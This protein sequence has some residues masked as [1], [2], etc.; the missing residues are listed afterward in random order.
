MIAGLVVLAAL[1][2]GGAAPLADASRA[3]SP[4]AG[5]APARETRAALG[6]Y[7]ADPGEPGEPPER[8]LNPPAQRPDA[9]AGEPDGD[10]CG[11]VSPILEPSCGAWFG[12]WPRTRADGTS[13][14]DLYGNVV[15]LEQRLGRR[16]D[17]VT[18]YYGWTQLPFDQADRALRDGGR[19]LL[20]DV[21]ARN[22]TTDRYV[23]WPSIAAGDHDGYLRQIATRAREFGTKVF[24]SF[25]QEPEYELERDLGDLGTPAD[26]AAAY[27]HIRDVFDAAGATNVVWVWWVMGYLGVA[28]W[29]P[30]L[31]P[32]DA[33]VDWISWDPYDFNACRGQGE[34]TPAATIGPFY[35]W[36]TENRLGDGKPLMLSE[37]GSHGTDR[38]D[39]YRGLAQA[40]PDRPRI[41]A[42]V[43][44]NSRVG[45]CDTRVT[46]SDD[47]WGGF[48]DLAHHP[49]L[50]QRRAG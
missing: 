28:S 32:G 41:K 10:G 22:F 42:I 38:G 18:R 4:R 33:Y 34:K 27:R 44:W 47:N 37:Y 45:D 46:S 49:Y 29:Y 1:V 5:S 26:Y 14:T 31:Y 20:V 8:S 50:Q 36:L 35:D 13:S 39:W 21:R 15:S 6:G 12:M 17:L 2:A 43:Q 3:D 30:A 11:V 40:L 48:R 19:L 25:H 16:L 7:P 24:F 9:G 23:S